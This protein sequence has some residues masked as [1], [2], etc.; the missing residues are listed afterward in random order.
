MM[1]IE[2]VLAWKGNRPGYDAQSFQ[3]AIRGMRNARLIIPEKE[4]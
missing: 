3:D 4:L 2:E 1:L